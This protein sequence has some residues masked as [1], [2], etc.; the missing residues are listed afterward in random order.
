MQNITLCMRTWREIRYSAS[1]KFRLTPAPV[2]HQLL[3]PVPDPCPKEN[4]RI[5]P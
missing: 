3:I 5:L 4:H 1:R 2:F